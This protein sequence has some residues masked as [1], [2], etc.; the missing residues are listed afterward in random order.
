[1]SV[2]DAVPREVLSPGEL[3]FERYR[4]RAGVVLA[5]AVF[6][7][8]LLLPMPGLSGP[9][10]RLAAILGAV[11][12]LWISEVLPMP[13]T[14]L[15]GAV[16]AVV[17]R[18]APAKDVLAPFAD[19]LIFLFIG[20]FILARG[21]FLHGLDRRFAYGVLALPWVGAR[22]S[23]ILFAFG[24]VTALLSAW[25]SNTATTAMMF[26]IGMSVL[27]FFF[28]EKEGVPRLDRRYATGL[29]LMTTFAASIGGLATPVGTPP[30]VIGL[31]FIRELVGVEI[32]F[33]RWM[34]IGVPVVIVLFAVMFTYLNALCPAGVRELAGSR[35]MIAERRAA[36][37]TW[38]T[39][40]RSAAI[41]FGFTV[42]LWVVPGAVALVLGER[43]AAYV[44]LSRSVPEGIAALAGAVLLFVL[45]GD[46]G[47]RAITWNEAARIDWGVVLLYGGGFAL[48]VLSFQT[49]LAEALGR[50]L[51][52]LLPV[53][54][55][56]GLLAAS[57]VIAV[58]VSEAT[59]NTASANMVVPVVIS[60]ATASGIDPLV[61]ALGAT[62]ASS[63]GF[64]LPVS[65]PCNA[66]VYGSGYVPLSRMIR[67]GA[68][69]DLAGIVV[70]ITVV[71]L[72]APM[73]R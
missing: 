69:L 15:L 2:V 66:I 39:G 49:G 42:M 64:M 72:L 57:V 5:P 18:V 41:A 55:E 52:G 29:M 38:T 9:A 70:V 1:M 27:A 54:G 28:E 47:E 36:L 63:L 11:V 68:L 58:L 33:F 24:A 65:T 44:A 17:M 37:G 32:P 46:R 73:L 48:G 60:I 6:I 56:F 26:G 61:P 31:G 12:V 3:A 34:L 8:L 10:H 45:P 43:S 53:S 67:Y 22:P 62:F 16:A 40:Q 51:T 7:G 59:S 4:R 35:A 50:G 13:V 71:S 23:R 19:P 25:I 14:A 20:A 30:N 21:I